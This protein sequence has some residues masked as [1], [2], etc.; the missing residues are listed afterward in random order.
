[1]AVTQNNY[2][3]DGS[4]VLYSFTFPYLATTDVKVKLDGVNTTAYTLA[5]AT[6]VQLNSAP[7]NGVKIIIF[8]NTDNDNKKATFYPGSAIKAEDLN[9]NIDQ[10]LYVAQEVDNNAMSSLGDTPMQGDLPLGQGLGIIF[11]G[12]T[13]DDNETRLGVVDPTADR[14]INLPNVSGTVVTTG[15]TGT[16]TSTMILDG[17]ILQLLVHTFRQAW[18]T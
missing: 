1:M 8:R 6:T 7:A 12:T 16:V 5:N 9:N 15:D 2:T 3:G 18:R 10:I 13:T 11:E 14:N 4:T 17:T